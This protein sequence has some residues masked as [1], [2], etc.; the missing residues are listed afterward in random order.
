MLMQVF[1]ASAGPISVAETD[2][3]PYLGEDCPRIW[4]RYIRSFHE[5]HVN[6]VLFGKI[7]QTPGWQMT[8]PL[9]HRR[10]RLLLYS[11]IFQNDRDLFCQTATVSSKICPKNLC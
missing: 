1:S 4:K 3:Y 7:L 5:T 10:H 8:E 6:R 11:K 9:L 2:K